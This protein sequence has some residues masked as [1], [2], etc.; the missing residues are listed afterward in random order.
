[1][2]LETGAIYDVDE[3]GFKIKIGNVDD[4]RPKIFEDFEEFHNRP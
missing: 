1:V 2:N 3:D 4:M